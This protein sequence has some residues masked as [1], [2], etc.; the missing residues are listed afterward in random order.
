MITASR[1][2]II[3]LRHAVSFALATSVSLGTATAEDT[4]VVSADTSD[5][6]E[7]GDI[8]KQA[9][10]GLLG[11]KKILDTP[12]S[13]SG[14]TS[15]YI[16]DR[17]AKNLGQII[18][19]DSSVRVTSPA[20][21]ILDSL[22]I[23]GFPIGEG[24]VGEVALNGVYGVAPNYQLLPQYIERV[25]VLKGPGA[26]LYGMSPNGGVGGVVNVITKRATAQSVTRL[27][28]TWE[29]DNQFGQYMDIGRLWMNPDGEMWGVRFNGGGSG[30]DLRQ[31][32]SSK[33]SAVGSLALDYAKGGFRA[34]L[35][36]LDQYQHVKSPV[37][38]FFVTSGV[39]VPS[40]P[41]GKTNI[42]QKGMW[43]KTRDQGA[44]LHT[45]Y[46]ISENTTLYADAGGGRTLVSRVSEQTPNIYNA[47][48]DV[49]STLTN[50][51]F[52]VNRYTFDTGLRRAF[53]T[54][55][56]EH[57]LTLQAS[58][59][60]DR[61]TVG[62]SSGQQVYSNI[63]SPVEVN[64]VKPSASSRIP[65]TSSSQLSGLALADTLTVIDGS[66]DV[67]PGVRFQRVR[68]DNFSSNGSRS[69]TYDESAFTPMLGLIYR[70][71]K[72][73]SLYAN[74]SEGLSKGDIAPGTAENAGQVMRP[75]RSRQYEVGMKYDQYG[76]LSSL[77]LFQ[78]TKPS[79]ALDSNNVY[80]ANSEQRNRG[81]ELSLSGKPVDSVNIMGSISLIDAEL[82]KSPTTGVKGN[83]PV[84]VSPVTA[85][86]GVEYELP[87]LR[88][89]S[90]NSQINYSGKQ[91]VNQANTQSI[92][93]WTTVDVG[94]AYKTRVYG[95]PATFRFDVQNVF[96]RSY[97]AGVAS[98]STIA[99][100]APRTFLASVT[101]DL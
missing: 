63:Y 90:V 28:T 84:G 87:V 62:S 18:Q 29:S 10:I 65:K 36:L 96:D 73:V 97:W 4:I 54:G 89:L 56:V 42:A 71:W 13:V 81:I 2:K 40:A 41:D 22:M 94:A 5:S 30:G 16:E 37:R 34:S 95:T 76:L 25:E 69:S 47:Q 66:V 79:G 78:I 58:Y 44:L 12:F 59:Y 27:T 86:V 33:N 53:T 48:G 88:G 50:Y 72:P 55:T 8:I 93:S 70:P 9:N 75:Y 7:T 52:N 64:V 23:R 17:Q 77:S 61:L 83:K 24:N 51:R 92:G 6:L 98:Y 57:Q 19:N 32:N 91:Y 67:I 49:V 45:E 35:D 31:D 101:V 20:G 11:N 99:Q 26:G 100:G 39:D 85:N 1:N 80:N 3:L 43:W 68:S 74:Y 38:P 60:H 82:T 46:D 21:G 15:K 14:Y